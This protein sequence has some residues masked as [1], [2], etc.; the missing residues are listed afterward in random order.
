V[1]LGQ[2]ADE[3]AGGYSRRANCLHDSWET[4]LRKDIE[5]LIETY[6]APLLS[7]SRYHQA[8]PLLVKQLQF[9]NLWHEDRT[10]SLHSLE[11]RVPFLDHRLVELLASVPWP[12]DKSL[13]WNKRIVRNCMKRLNTG[14]DVERTKVG[15]FE[16]SDMRSVDII[17]H[18]FACRIAREFQEKYEYAPDFPHDR[19]EFD[20]FV[21][22]VLSRGPGF[23]QHSLVLLNMMAEAIFSHQCRHGTS[24]ESIEVGRN[25]HST[26]NV[27]SEARWSEINRFF[28]EQP[29][30]TY[31]WRCDDC[32]VLPSGGSIF[33][34]LLIP[35][36]IEAA[37]VVDSEVVASIQFPSDHPWLGKFLR[38]L[39]S[40]A[41]VNF[42]IQEWCDEFDIVRQ[43]FECILNVLL[44]CGLI[45]TPKRDGCYSQKLVIGR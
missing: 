21:D 15:F 44:Q 34:K 2:G 27:V 20:N 23:Y 40:N 7:Y 31:E 22:K 4:Y 42:A 17:I 32:P 25:R 8:M 10:S 38:L 9:Y 43:E 5:P 41:A 28:A 1:L 36:I 26:L 29:V 24:T 12:L 35:G 30:L 45:T 14:F 11:A 37:L 6:G 19:V 16:T 18:G 13:F 3:F 33:S 39:G